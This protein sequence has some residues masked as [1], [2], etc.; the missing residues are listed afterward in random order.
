MMDIYL[1]ENHDFIL[2]GRDLR[3]TTPE[4]DV[5]QRLSIRLQFLLGEWFLDNT[6]GLPYTQKFFQVGTSLEKIY[7]LIRNEIIATDGVNE[8][9]SLSLT[10]DSDNRTLRIDFVV[11]DQFSKKSSSVEVEI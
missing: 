6:K 3:M 11:R 2:G 4:E 10:P 1:D 7:D 5:V 8:F 9:V